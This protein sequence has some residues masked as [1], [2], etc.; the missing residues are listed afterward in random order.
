MAGQRPKGWKL[1]KAALATRKSATMLAFGFSSGLPFALLIGTLNA[2]LGDAKI[3]LATIGVLSWIGLAYAFKFLWSPL[4]DRVSLPLLGRLGR[5]TSW[6]VICQVGLIVSFVGLGATNPAI[7]IGWFAIFAV[8]GAFASATQDIAVDAWRIDVADEKT[9]VELLSAVYQ[10]GYRTASIVGGAFALLLA[11]RIPWGTVYFVMAALVL[12]VMIVAVTAPDTQRPPKNIIEEGLEQP[13]AINTSIRFAAL[14]IVGICW[15]WAIVTLGV[16][17]ASMLAAQQAGTKAPSVAD[18][19]ATDGPW[20]IVATVFVPLVVAAGV[21]WLKAHRKGIQ[22]QG[23]PNATGG[24][25]VMNHIYGALVS[26]LAELSERLRWGVLIIIGFILTYAL[27]YNIWSSFA[28]PFYLDYLHYTKDQVAFASKVF[29][30]FMTMIGISLGGYLFGRIGKFPTVLIGAAVT[31]LG[32]LLYADLAEGGA[33]IDAFTH[34][35]RIDRLL[36]FF[37]ADERMVRLL[38]AICYENV[39]TGIALT[40]FVAYLSGIISKKFTAVQYALLSSLTFLVGS[41]GRGVAGESFDKYGYAIVFR[42]TAAAGLVAV[43]FVLLEWARVAA[44]DRKVENAQLPPDSGAK[45]SE[46]LAESGQPAR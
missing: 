17:M 28:F 14:A 44:Q 36:G 30:I 34:L 1:L 23:K 26:P 41:L 18:F 7:A 40:A 29:G 46:A 32:N 43:L 20:I 37:G 11:A 13:G 15:A 27:C 35:L 21:N 10:F 6:I 19:T 2:W 9:S 45:A 5:R 25:A 38:V 3:N 22:Q 31:P 33:N 39:A 16:F 42:W 24:R 4:V 8:I 12:V